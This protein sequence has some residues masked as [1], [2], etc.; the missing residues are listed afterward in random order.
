MSTSVDDMV[1]RTAKDNLQLPMAVAVEKTQTFLRDYFANA[2]AA[3]WLVASSDP[4]MGGKSYK[5]EVAPNKQR[6]TDRMDV[7]YWLRFDGTNRQTFVTQ[8]ITK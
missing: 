4:E 3:G 1:T 6:P 2:E 5:F 7:S 8:T